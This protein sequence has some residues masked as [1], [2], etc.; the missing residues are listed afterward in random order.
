MDGGSNEYTIFAERVFHYLRVYIDGKNIRVEMVRDDG[1]IGDQ[2]E[3]IKGSTAEVPS[4]NALLQ[5]YP[6]PFNARTHIRF[7]ISKPG[8]IDLSLYNVLGQKVETLDKGFKEAGVYEALISA[9]R[10][11]S[12]VYFI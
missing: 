7:S 3:I 1:S 4:T 9:D 10:F 8:S 12:G 11:A 5:N 6:N 2:F